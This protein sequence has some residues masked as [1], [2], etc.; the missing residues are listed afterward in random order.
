MPS[1][2]ETSHPGLLLTA[3]WD[4]LDSLMIARD[5][6]RA[7]IQMFKIIYEVVHSLSLCVLRPAGRLTAAEG[8]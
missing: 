5:D 7:S 1:G 4:P 2:V 6:T 3:G 8:V